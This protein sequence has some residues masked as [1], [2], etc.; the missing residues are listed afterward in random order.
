RDREGRHELQQPEDQ[1][2]VDLADDLRR[3]EV[4]RIGAEDDV[5]EI[6]D[7]ERDRQRYHHREPLALQ[8]FEFGVFRLGEEVNPGVDRFSHSFSFEWTEHQC[9]ESHG[10]KVTF[11]M[12]WGIPPKVG[13]LF[14]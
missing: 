12:R 5:E 2:D 3:H 11:S 10:P 1:T 7:E 8:R 6:P 9:P 13:S 14:T 4:M